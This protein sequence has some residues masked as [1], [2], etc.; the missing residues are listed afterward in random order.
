MPWQPGRPKKPVKFRKETD[1]FKLYSCAPRQLP[2][3]ALPTN[4][5]VDL[6]MEW[7]M[8]NH[9][10]K[11]ADAVDQVAGEVVQIWAA[12]S[13]S[14]KVRLKKN[15]VSINETRLTVFDLIWIGLWSHYLT[16]K[17][18]MNTN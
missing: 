2:H 17:N 6:A 12:L 4:Q 18:K 8:C 11:E 5:D 3:D 7:F 15:I 16:L 1:N 13:P 9:D 14:T 10:L